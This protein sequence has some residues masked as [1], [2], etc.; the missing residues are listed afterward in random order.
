MGSIEK[1]QGED[2]Y[3]LMKGKMKMIISQSKDRHPF[4]PQHIKDALKVTFKKR[5]FP[6]RK[7]LLI[8]MAMMVIQSAPFYGEHSIAFLFVRTK[9]DWDYKEYSKY[10]SIV[11]ALSIA[12]SH[13]SILIINRK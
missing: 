13:S 8:L 6:N 7:Y 1:K 5:P 12:G 3:L 4:S 10:S 11:S 9:F 2:G